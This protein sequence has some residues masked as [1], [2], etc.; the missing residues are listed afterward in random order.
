MAALVT[1]GDFKTYLKYTKTDQDTL[2]QAILDAVEEHLE[3]E[4]DQ[5]FQ[6]SG[7]VTDELR[8]GDGTKVLYLRRPASAITNIKVSALSDASN[9]QETIPAADVKIDPENGRRVVRVQ[10]GVFRRGTFN[11]F[12]TYT[13]AANLPKIATEAVKEGG[14]MVYR[15]RGSEHVISE[16][17]GELGS[18]V[19]EVERRFGRLPMWDAAVAQLRGSVVA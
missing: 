18:H 19:L 6:A 8:S 1:L 13:A 9:P 15:L 4:T 5:V 3:N 7:A 16:S 12:A 17:L 14:A 11:L 10:N 2:L